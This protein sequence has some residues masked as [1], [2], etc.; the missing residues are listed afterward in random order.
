M[1]TNPLSV[2]KLMKKLILRILQE[3]YAVSEIS[4]LIRWVTPP[5]KV[6]NLRFEF[7]FCF[8]IPQ[9]FKFF[10]FALSSLFPSLFFIWLWVYVLYSIH[11]LLILQV[12]FSAKW[13]WSDPSP[14]M[15]NS[16]SLFTNSSCAFYL[17]LVQILHCVLVS[18]RNC[19]WNFKIF[20]SEFSGFCRSNRYAFHGILIYSPT[21]SHDL[22][23]SVR[24][25]H[26]SREWEGF[27][28]LEPL[29]I[30]WNSSGE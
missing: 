10:N 3:L 13:M 11:L 17:K 22:H 4:F 7:F 2:K 21:I 25:W 6:E 30:P 27:L 15:L 20:L 23:L 18:W 28:P 19:E 29:R 14:A 1:K 26:M 16:T 12:D 8:E 9:F 5:T 24:G